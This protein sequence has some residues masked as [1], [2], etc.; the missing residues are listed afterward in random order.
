MKIYNG[1]RHPTRGGP[2][3]VFVTKDGIARELDPR[4]DIYNHSPTGFQWGYPGSGPAQLALALIA[5][6]TGDDSLTRASYQRFKQEVVV[7]LP[8]EWELTHEQIIG[9]LR[10]WAERTQKAP[11]IEMLLDNLTTQVFGIS[12]KDPMCVICRSTKVKEKDFEDI[13]SWREFHISRMCQECQ[14]KTFKR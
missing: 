2:G 13:L 1:R 7:S 6:A 9:W 5:D 3:E 10:T 14:N 12:R 8:V 4:S 11:E